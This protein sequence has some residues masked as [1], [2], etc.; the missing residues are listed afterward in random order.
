ML[1]WSLGWRH[2]K[3]DLHKPLIYRY[4]DL[5]QMTRNPSGKE[6]AGGILD[7]DNQQIQDPH[8]IEQ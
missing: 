4:P 1:D 3:P 2:N 7:Q 6:G 8:P 5:S